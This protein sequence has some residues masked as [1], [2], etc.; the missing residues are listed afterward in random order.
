MRM[1]S[2]N[3]GTGPLIGR[4]LNSLILVSSFKGMQFSLMVIT[5]AAE[6][7]DVP[8]CGERRAHVSIGSSVKPAHFGWRGGWLASRVG[9]NHP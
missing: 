7:K 9:G 6:G 1:R 2:I 4:R 3:L 5:A 8:D